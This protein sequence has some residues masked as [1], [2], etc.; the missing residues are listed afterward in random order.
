MKPS[1]RRHERSCD[2]SDEGLAALLRTTLPTIDTPERLKEELG[3]RTQALM[4]QAR[5]PLLLR[6]LVTSGI[7]LALAI[8][9]L[10]LWLPAERP[11][12]P[13]RE[14]V[15]P[16]QHVP[17]SG[18]AERGG[19]P[20]TG[21]AEVQGAVTHIAGPQPSSVPDSR[22]RRAPT[23]PL[24]AVERSRRVPV[25]P[26]PGSPVPYAARELP[27]DVL[28]ETVIVSAQA[29]STSPRPLPGPPCLPLGDGELESARKAARKGEIPAAIAHYEAAMSLPTR[30]ASR[31]THLAQGPLAEGPIVG[32]RQSGMA[33]RK[34]VSQ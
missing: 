1:S 27:I 26:A 24:L 25:V 19:P 8:A 3:A 13:Q 2:D 17:Q 31:A 4:H 33:H 30:P 23:R 18:Q 6:P 32:G 21:P 10:C 7:G 20:G 16:A 14:A 29:G 11:S 22:R 5:R 15:A 9:A 28:Y 12:L 34:A